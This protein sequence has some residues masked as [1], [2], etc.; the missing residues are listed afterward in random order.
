MT[1]RAVLRNTRTYTR[2]A[3]NSPALVCFVELVLCMA[4]IVRPARPDELSAPFVRR[5]GVAD[6]IAVEGPVGPLA[7]ERLCL[8][9]QLDGPLARIFTP[10]SSF[11]A[12]PA[13]P[14]WRHPFHIRACRIVAKYMISL[15]NPQL[16]PSPEKANKSGASFEYPARRAV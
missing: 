6:G 16:C 2:Q 5:I 3:Q 11:F 9:A 12:L 8:H 4:Q 14:V 7:G 15:N 10:P 1:D 13:P